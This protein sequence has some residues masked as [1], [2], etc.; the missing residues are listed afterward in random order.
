MWR[1]PGGMR[2]THTGAIMKTLKSFLYPFTPIIFF[3]LTLL[4]IK[5]GEFKIKPQ[6]TRTHYNSYTYNG[7]EESWDQSGALEITI[8]SPLIKNE[9]PNNLSYYRLPRAHIFSED[10]SVWTLTANRGVFARKDHRITF[11][12]KVRL[13][14]PATDSKPDTTLKTRTANYNTLTRMA[15]CPEPTTVIQPKLTI[16][17]D[18]ASIDVK[19]NTIT[20]GKNMR[21]ISER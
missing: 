13:H 16:T 11:I 18:D 12:G 3:A 4:L 6:N 9:T 15:Y 20:N 1:S 17:M 7:T 21:I 14:R 19:N 5:L 2:V 8:H 10:G